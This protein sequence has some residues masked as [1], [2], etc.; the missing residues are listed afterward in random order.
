MRRTCPVVF[1]DC[2]RLSFRRRWQIVQQLSWR[3]DQPD[4]LHVT[5]ART[6]CVAVRTDAERASIS[7]KKN[8]LK[9]MLANGDK[10]SS[11]YKFFYSFWLCMLNYRIFNYMYVQFIK[12]KIVYTAGNLFFFAKKTKLDNLKLKYLIYLLNCL[13]FLHDNC[14][15]Q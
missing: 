4:Q 8:K 15:Y 3:P 5:F 13:F 14:S 9:F 10:I 2:H 11:F 7:V 1:P 12:I 6:R